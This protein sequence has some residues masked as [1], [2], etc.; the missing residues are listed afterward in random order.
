MRAA[1]CAFAL[2]LSTASAPAE[3][4]AAPGR[5]RY[6]AHLFYWGRAD[7]NDPPREKCAYQ[8]PGTLKP[9][10]DGT[11]YS[12]DNPGWWLREVKDM[13]RAR[14]D[15][16]LPVCW[17]DKVHFSTSK[18]ARLVDAIRAA[19]SPLK[20]GLYDDT[21]GQDAEYKM[22]HPGA[23][24]VPLARDTW[25]LFFQKW[26][27]FFTVIPMDLWATH[28]GEPVER[29]GRPLILTFTPQFFDT[30]DQADAMWAWCKV[31][32][33]KEFKFKDPKGRDVGVEPWLLLDWKWSTAA[34]ACDK[35]T[36]GFCIYSASIRGTLTFTHKGPTGVPY[37]CS[38]LG[39][40]RDDRLIGKPENHT[41]RSDGAWFLEN[42]RKIPKNCDLAVIES[43]NELYEGSA[44]CRMV[45]W[46]K[47][48]GGL[49]PETFYIDLLRDF[50]GGPLPS[51]RRGR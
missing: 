50:R 34:K 12:Y 10:E 17:G 30:L 19:N 44:M 11:W 1:S 31:E 33:K 20:V 45:D 46:P 9:Y 28:N 37:V 2:L 36:D 47:D 41:P 38:N 22:A 15:Y 13:T 26:K 51:E 14:L 43:R 29:G 27:S 23:A 7:A 42:L 21:A 25:P 24:K 48:G 35:V 49:L 32:F 5:T 6:A 39:P 8:P 40:G 16:V 18:L 4:Q 3:P